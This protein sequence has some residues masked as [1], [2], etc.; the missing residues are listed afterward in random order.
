[1]LKFERGSEWRRWDLQIH[2]PFSELN[3]GFKTDIETYAAQM[4][5]RAIESDIAVI[6]ITDYFSIE[7]YREIREIVRNDDRLKQLLGPENAARAKE[8]LLLPNIELR[9]SVF[10][11]NGRVN[12]HVIFSDDLDPDDIEEHFFRELKFTAESNPGDGD[13]SRSLTLRNLEDVGKRL[14]VQHVKFRDQS[15]LS[16]GMNTASVSHEEVTKVLGQPRFKD[17]YLL[18]VVADEDLPKISWDGQGHR[19]RKNFIQKAHM[20][21]AANPST[22][23]W[24]LGKKHATPEEFVSEFKSLKPCIH[25]S[26]A[27]TFDQLFNPDLER[28]CWIHTDPTFAGLR[29]LLNEPESRVFIGSEPPELYHLKQTKTKYVDRVSFTRNAKAPSNAMWFSGGIPLNSGLVAIIGNKGSGKTAIADILGLLGNTHVGQDYFSFLSKRRFLAPRQHLGDLFQASVRWL[30]GR[31]GTKLLG[32]GIDKNAPELVK[33]IPQNYLETICTELNEKGE[34]EFDRELM[35]V[36]FSHVTESDRLGTHS[37]QELIDRTTLETEKQIQQLID[38][39][40]VINQQVADWEKRSSQQFRDSVQAQLEQRVRELESLNEARPAVVP[41]PQTD[42]SIPE[43][44]TELTTKL[45]QI[46]GKITELNLKAQAE[47][48]V[49]RGATARI[50]VADALLARIN[51][52]EAQVKNFLQNSFG[53]TELL[54]LDIS[55]IVSLTVNR[56]SVIVKRQDDVSVQT[57]A[58]NALN[59]DEQGSLRWEVNRLTTEAADVRAQLDEPTRRYHEYQIALGEWQE[60][61]D[62]LVGTAQ[63]I[64]SVEGLK[65]QLTA[66]GDLPRQIASAEQNRIELVRKIYG[67]KERLVNQYGRLHKPVQEFIERENYTELQFQASIVVD[68]LREKFLAKI[69]Q[70]RAGS[71]YGQDGSKRLDEMI[72]EGDFTTFDDTSVFISKLLDALRYDRRQQ[73]NVGDVKLTD[74][75]TQ[76]IGVKDL[77]NFLF[78]LSYL[79]P[80]F[81]LRWQGKPLDRLSPGE[82][83]VLLLVFYLLVDRGDTPLIIDQPEE[84]LDNQTIAST[85]VPLIKKAKRRRQVIIVTHNP[86]LAVVCDADQVI[87]AS[88]NK[89]EG[90]QITYVSG[91]IEEP[92]IAQK[93]IDVLEGTKPAFDLRDA[94]YSVLDT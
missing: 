35:S 32:D 56:E 4:F 71:F 36:I 43:R 76:G 11:D 79:R 8:I 38:Q 21:F 84:N 60:K 42:P 80:Q 44:D 63:D 88:L 67:A 16:V 92:E 24:S 1:M 9:S 81:E 37:L 83:G 27:H 2:T 41:E 12:F 17:K 34:T 10:V 5:R 55:Q 86:N 28:Y 19:I 30:S 51:N 66:F 23:E 33:Y 59:P 50:A 49:D 3:N 6:G 69:H 45:A 64:Q 89:A 85:L 53:D 78:G 18:V 46:N 31:E 91:S 73:S 77:Y 47:E 25:G 26:D 87:H 68:G 54:E 48:D 93:I 94:K 15:D 13:D 40:D 82:R 74:Q 58:R 62:R 72:Q 29:Y 52:L 57:R 22:R 61:Y 65:A 7:G 14:K 90:N 75:L 70:G 39:L 20:L